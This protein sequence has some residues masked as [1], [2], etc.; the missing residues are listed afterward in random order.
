MAGCPEPSTA[1][2]Y[3][4]API[5]LGLFLCG[6]SAVSSTN[7]GGADE[8]WL[9]SLNDRLA[10]GVPYA[11]RPLNLLWT[12]PGGWLDRTGFTGYHVMNGAY[13][14]LAGL[15]LF[16]LL[17]RL[18]MESP[19]L[20]FLAAAFAMTWAPGDQARLNTVKGT[21]GSGSAMGLVLAVALLVEG[22]WRGSRALLVASGAVAWVT[23]RSYEATLPLLLAAPLLAL[24]LP[25]GARGWPRAWW[26]AWAGPVALA[27]AQALA[28]PARGGEDSHYQLKL[29]SLDPKPAMV[30]S[31]L[32]HQYESHLAPLVTS[33]PRELRNNRVALA[34]ALLAG[35][36]LLLHCLGRRREFV[37]DRVPRDLFAVAGGLAAAGLGYAPYVFSPIGASTDRTQY[38]S[39]LGI[40]TALAAAAVLVARPFPPRWRWVVTAALGSWVVAVGT[41]RTLAMQRSWDGKS[42]FPRQAAMLRDLRTIAPDLRPGTLVV[43]ADRCATWPAVFT[44]R[45]AVEWTYRRQTTGFLWLPGPHDQLFYPTAFDADG[46][47]TT[48]WES[49]QRAWDDPPTFHRYD[50]IVAVRLRPDGCRTELVDQWPEELPPLPPGARYAPRE[51]VL[52][53][54]P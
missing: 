36:C 10:L 32:A 24:C 53:R 4:L 18:R 46:V 51:R 35:G 33:D 22:R 1:K 25:S 47:R 14:W 28:P 44:F 15:L 19:L 21:F 38:F 23:I 2:T 54:A 16:M 26:L 50:E 3:L 41:G 48:P 30:I 11:N 34:A 49:I 12:L 7:F 29:T 40:A 27:T 6:Y 13:L 43:L 5:L 39:G 52:G 45:H 31:R 20:A 42:V 37:D 9:R 17:R 8:W